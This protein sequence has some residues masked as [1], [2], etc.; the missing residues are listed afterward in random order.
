[1]RVLLAAVDD[2]RESRLQ[3]MLEARGH[4][5]VRAVS[6]S[7]ELLSSIGGADHLHAAIV[8]QRSL[9]R[10]WP[11]L[12]RQLRKQAPRLPVVLLLGPRADR[13]WRLAI[14]AGAFEA[15]SA[16][17]PEAAIQ[18]V[19]RALAYVVGKAVDQLSVEGAPGG[20]TDRLLA[21]GPAPD[22]AV[23][24]RKERAA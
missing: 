3:G 24:T 8:S 10:R 7:E 2:P 23:A 5:V 13:A 6:K 11:R 16:R 21:T 14:L 19:Y 12:L 17:A 9:G 18:A 22:M 1:M 15:A 20:A 4:E